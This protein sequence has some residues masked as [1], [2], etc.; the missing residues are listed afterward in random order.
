MENAGI[1]G[2]SASPDRQHA[3]RRAM[4]SGT[5]CTRRALRFR[6]VLIVGYVSSLEA[7]AAFLRRTRRGIPGVVCAIAAAEPLH[8]DAR[9]RIEAGT[10]RA[11][12]QHLRIPRV[13]VDC[14]RMRAP[15]RVCTFTRR[16]WSSKRAITE[17]PAVGHSDH[18]SSQLRHAVRAI[19][20]RR[21]R[22]I[23]DRSCRCG[24]GLPLLKAIEGR[25]LDAL[26]TADGR[27][28]PGEFFPHLLK[29]IPEVADYPRRAD[30]RS[31]AS[32]SRRCW[33]GR[34]PIA[35]RG[36]SGTKSGRCS[37]RERS[38]RFSPSTRSPD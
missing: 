33:P 23:A 9:R 35:A 14:R 1:R 15:R 37:V 11:A 25:V 19:R 2:D 13:H 21:P 17:S 22:P 3:S 6:P 5:T 26:R 31:I 4:R 12:L 28:V 10:R 38:T 18:R 24:R 36:C 7:F 34:Y 8:E 29:E 32:S 20:N 16:T 30:E 27:T